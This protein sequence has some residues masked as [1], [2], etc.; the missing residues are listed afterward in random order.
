MKV[1][2]LCQINRFTPFDPPYYI[3][4]P[5][6]PRRTGAQI[7]VPSAVLSRETLV[8]VLALVGVG[9]CML[10]LVSSFLRHC[11]CCAVASWLGCTAVAVALDQP[12]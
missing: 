12:H 9:V 5:R 7:S 8:W 1:S 10:C 2:D 4:H 6:P 3:P 11:C